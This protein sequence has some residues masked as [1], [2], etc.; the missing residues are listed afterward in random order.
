MNNL[1]ILGAGLLGRLLALLL[2]NHYRVTLFEQ[3]SIN[4]SNTTGR[5]AAAMVAPTAESVVAS[6]YLVEMGQISTQLWPELLQKLMLPEL[7]QQNGTLVI[8]HRHDS[9]DLTHFEQRLKQTNQQSQRLLQ[10]QLLALEPELAQQ[11]NQGLYISGE[12]HVDNQGL[13]ELTAQQ[14]ID[15]NVIIKEHVQADLNNIKTEFDVVFDCRGLGAKTEPHNKTNLRGVRGEVA[16]VFAPEVNLSRPIRL[17]HP[18]YP[19]YIAPKPNNIYVIG[20]TEIESEDDKAV[21]LRSAMELLSAAYT[22]HKGFAEA[23]IISIQSGLR[24]TLLDNEPAITL[25]GNV[26]QANGLYRHGY[27]IAPYILQQLILTLGIQAQPCAF[28]QR[29]TELDKRL[30]KEIT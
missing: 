11:F 29:V 10:H 17:M 9:A 5:L 23:E 20:A 13:Y 30:I 26:I 6:D 7:Y 28:S 21:T 2:Q 25:H 16:R 14:L 19:I 27:L 24:P 3:G 22:V 8:A 12:G 15:S 18:R 4:D 1:A